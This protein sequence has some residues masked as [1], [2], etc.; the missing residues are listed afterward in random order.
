MSVRYAAQGTSYVAQSDLEAYQRVFVVGHEMRAA[1]AADLENGVVSRNILAGESGAIE[2]LMPG[3]RVVMIAAGA[4]SAE[5]D[6]YRAANGRVAAAG[7]SKIGRS[8]GD[9]GAAGNLIE[10]VV[11]P[12]ADGGG[13]G[14]PSTDG[15]DEV[16]NAAARLAD[17]THSRVLQTDNGVVYDRHD[18]SWVASDLNT[19]LAVNPPVAVAEDWQINTRADGTSW[20]FNPTHNVWEQ[21]APDT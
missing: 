16:V 5:A 17:D 13:G 1:G 18:D 20:L 7:S 21:Y 14:G 9:A 6:V 15:F 2:L 3:E 19:T 12:A 11:E 4:I 8:I 10:I